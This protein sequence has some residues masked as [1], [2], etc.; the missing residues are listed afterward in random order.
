MPKIKIISINIEGSKHLAEVEDFLIS[1]NPDIVCIQELFQIDLDRFQEKTGWRGSFSPMTDV[2]NET[3]YKIATNGL[4]GLGIF[5]KWSF[6][7]IENYF[8]R[9]EEDFVPEF[10][11]PY[12]PNRLIMK[13]IINKEGFDFPVANT[14]FTWSVGGKITD[15]QRHNFAKMKK[16]LSEFDP[17]ILC[18]DFNTPRGSELYDDLSK[19]YQDA[20]P[21]EVDTTID[22]VLHYAG[23]LKLVVDGIFVSDAFEIISGRTE[24]GVS[25]H[26]AVVVELQTK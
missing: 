1:E 22:P 24:S 26:K 21:P 4:W 17:L 14:H 13:T 12:S 15:D 7:E 3:I 19:T 5:S 2:K 25:D 16:I 11:N 23:G 10:V 8:Y 6:S 20:L 18:G 9:G